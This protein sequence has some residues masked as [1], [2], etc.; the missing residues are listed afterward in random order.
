MGEGGR[1]NEG[2]RVEKK[3]EGKEV[4]VNETT[5]KISNRSSKTAGE[6]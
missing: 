3:G 4:K 2:E 6:H 5:I 1:I